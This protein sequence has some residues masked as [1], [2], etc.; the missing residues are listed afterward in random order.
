LGGGLPRVTVPGFDYTAR[1]APPLEVPHAQRIA[2]IRKRKAQERERAKINA[3][4]RAAGNRG[5]PPAQ[6]TAAAPPAGEPVRRFGRSH[7]SGWGGRGRRS[8]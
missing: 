2:E 3:A 1:H 7:G 4:R 5:R 6:P 8:R